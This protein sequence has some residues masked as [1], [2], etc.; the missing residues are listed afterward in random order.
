MSD[1][2]DD[3]SPLARRHRVSAIWVVPLMA[4][5]LGIWLVWQNLLDEGPAVTVT[6]ESGA[7]IRADETPVRYKDQ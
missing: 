6:W 4:A 1:H 2:P 5:L 7:G 3:P